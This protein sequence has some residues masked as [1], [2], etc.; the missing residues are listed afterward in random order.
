[1]GATWLLAH[2]NGP[3]ALLAVVVS[4]PQ[5]IHQQILLVL[6]GKHVPQKVVFG[7]LLLRL[8]LSIQH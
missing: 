6:R 5:R 3:E 4:T 7:D 8:K 1:M 2:L